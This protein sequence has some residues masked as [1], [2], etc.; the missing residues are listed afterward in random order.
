MWSREKSLVFAEN[1][2][3]AVH[4]EPRRYTDSA[5]PALA[6]ELIAFLINGHSVSKIK[7]IF[8]ASGS[9]RLRI[10]V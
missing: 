2:N 10:P 6:S 3:P 5:I 9:K 4:S 8:V 7:R 1:Q